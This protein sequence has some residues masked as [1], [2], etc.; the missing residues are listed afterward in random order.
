MIEVY[1][2]LVELALRALEPNEQGI[3]L[4]PLLLREQVKD[5]MEKRKKV[6]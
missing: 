1:A 2:D 5:E 4:V 3:K 6:V